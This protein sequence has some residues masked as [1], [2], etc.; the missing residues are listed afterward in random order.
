MS[1][2]LDVPSLDCVINY[3]PPKKVE[4]YVHRVGRTARGLGEGMA[5][6]LINNNQYHWFAKMMQSVENG[7]QME[8]YKLPQ[9]LVEERQDQMGFYTEELNKILALE[10]EGTLNALEPLAQAMAC[11]DEEDAQTSDDVDT[12]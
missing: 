9:D 10:D 4:T 12:D 3:E 7:D 2:G 11:L 5:I 1:R 8:K 6:T